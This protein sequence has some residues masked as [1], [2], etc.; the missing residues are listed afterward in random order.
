MRDKPSKILAVDDVADNLFLMQTILEEEGY[1]VSTSSNGLDAI[2]TVEA[3]PPDLI[4]LDVMMPDVDGYEVTLR[5]RS[6]L[7]LPFIPIL[8][9]TADRSIP[10]VN[11]LDLGADDFVYKPIKVDEL[12]ARV[13][14]LL[15]LKH[16]IDAMQKMTLA[17]EDFV[18]RLT[19]DLRTPLVAADR[20]LNLLQRGKFGSLSPNAIEAIATISDSN[21]NLLSL[22][23]T[24]LE[25]HR[26]EAGCKTLARAPFNLKKMIREVVK[27][28]EPVAL[29][30]GLSLTY[31]EQDPTPIKIMGDRL[32][33]RR[34]MTNLVGNAIKFTDVGDVKIVVRQDVTSV[35][36]SVEDTGPGIRQSEQATLF[37]RFRTGNHSRAGSG[38]GLH[39]S[40]RIV[41]AHAGSIE[42]ASKVG[43]GSVFTVRLPTG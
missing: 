41:E 32:E 15:R 16:S 20:M 6:L 18:S 5:I 35:S 36:I 42:V 14:S 30:K 28:L 11:G 7:Q 39:L 4:L 37:E 29:D 27:E 1:C 12:L 26:F 25:V 40:R 43:F 2:A 8:L 34:V 23:N 33:L 22:V 19:H 31:D 38:L 10:R 3:S 17:R 13:R 9:I 21:Q 24:L